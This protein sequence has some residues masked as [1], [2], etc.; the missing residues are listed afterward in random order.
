M[1]STRVPRRA[2]ARDRVV[3]PARAQPGEVGGDVLRAGQDDEV[4]AGELGRAPRPDDVGH[5]LQRLELV[6]V[7]R[8]RVAHDGDP[9]RAGPRGRRRGAVLVRQPVLDARQQADVGHP[10]RALELLRARARAARSSPRNLFSTKPR[11]ELAVL[12]GH[13]RP[14]AVEVREGAAA[15]DV[16]DEHD[17]RVGRVRGAHVREIGGAQVRLGR[18]PG[19]LEQHEL[20]LREQLLQR[21]LRDR[22]E[23]RRPLA[24]RRCG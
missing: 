13:E 5:L 8:R 4:G 7:R 6:E 18:A 17:G 12:V 1:P 10:G 11:R 22:P 16:R 3:E 21:P 20:V 23:R 2:A 19:A 9:R 15:V 14:R 24:P